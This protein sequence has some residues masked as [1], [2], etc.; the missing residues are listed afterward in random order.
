MYERFTDRARKAMAFANQEAQ[1]LDSDRIQ[2][3]HVLLGLLLTSQG[4]ATNAL[5][6]LSVNLDELKLVTE[7]LAAGGKLEREPLNRESSIR[8]V[9]R[10]LSGR[11]RPSTSKR[12]PPDAKAKKVIE[13]AM[14]EARTLRHNYVG[15]EHM[16]LGLLRSEGTIAADALSKFGMTADRVRKEIVNLLT[17]DS[18]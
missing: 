9:L 7:M 1:R 2:T 10:W 14:D 4:V 16:I 18:A 17:P 15:T 6:N 13:L 11:R 12:L 3:E 5:Q 8:R